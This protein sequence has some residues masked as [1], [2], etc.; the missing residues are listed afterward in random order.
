ME[1]VGMSAMFKKIK[2]RPEGKELHLE[3]VK[4]RVKS[5]RRMK[6]KK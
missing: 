4:K 6:R 5:R 3:G 1:V 2:R